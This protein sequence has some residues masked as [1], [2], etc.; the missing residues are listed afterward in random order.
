MSK[1]ES[2]DYYKETLHKEVEKI[3]EQDT[4]FLIKLIHIIRI[5]TGRTDNP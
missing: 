3:P 4:T 2:G 1:I 5:H